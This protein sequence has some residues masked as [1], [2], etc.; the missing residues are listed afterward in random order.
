MQSE[1]EK[2][3]DK[4]RSRDQQGGRER[5]HVCLPPRAR[6]KKKCTEPLCTDHHPG[7]ELDPLEEEKARQTWQAQAYSEGLLGMSG[8]SWDVFNSHLR[9]SFDQILGEVRS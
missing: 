8:R 7:G 9:E 3:T 4:S 6:E 5:K 2:N 1:S